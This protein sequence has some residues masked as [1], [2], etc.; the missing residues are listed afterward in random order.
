MARILLMDDDEPLRRILQRVLEGA[1][2]EVYAAGDGNAG[3]ALADAI[4]PE[5]VVTDIVMPDREGLETIG[6]LRRVRPQTPIVAMSGNCD[7]ESGDYL[8]IARALG[9]DRTLGKPFVPQELVDAVA[10]L[11]GAGVG[12]PQG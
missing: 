8:R 7:P 11:L 10:Q 1:G 5:L 9:A 6:E 2:H 4:D 3:L 12:R